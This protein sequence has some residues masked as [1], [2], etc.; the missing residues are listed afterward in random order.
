MM[1]QM[2]LSVGPLIREEMVPTSVEFFAFFSKLD[3][4]NERMDKVE[5]NDKDFAEKLQQMEQD[6]AAMKVEQ[7]RRD[8][9]LQELGMQKVQGE[10]AD[11]RVPDDAMID[12]PNVQVAREIDVRQQHGIP[13]PWQNQ[14]LGA[15][16]QGEGHI[17]DGYAHC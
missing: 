3:V 8:E 13:D 16:L 4:T 1:T 12:N 7:E 14:K 6:Y 10:V 9:V 11:S 2:K 15:N 17:V 5:Q